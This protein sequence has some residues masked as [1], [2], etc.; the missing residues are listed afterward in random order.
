MNLRGQAWKAERNVDS[1][2]SFSYTERFCSLTA[3][4]PRA[5]RSEMMRFLFKLLVK[6]KIP[7]IRTTYRRWSL[8]PTPPTSSYP[9]PLSKS[10]KLK[11]VLRA[12]EH[13]YDMKEFPW[14]HSYVEIDEGAQTQW[15]DGGNS[16]SSKLERHSESESRMYGVHP[17]NRPN[18]IAKEAD[19][20]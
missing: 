9:Y 20:R 12:N 1:P 7:E 2:L 6:K 14:Y 15:G 19:I 18:N 13:N 4:Y 16:D 8:R 17:S 10:T 3:K 5:G 11:H